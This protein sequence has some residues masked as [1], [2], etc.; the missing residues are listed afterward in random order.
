MWFWL[1]SMF[2]AS[3]RRAVTWSRVPLFCILYPVL[4][5]YIIKL[6]KRTGNK[7]VI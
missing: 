1:K 5:Y 3:F 7:I 2:L 6:N 4:N